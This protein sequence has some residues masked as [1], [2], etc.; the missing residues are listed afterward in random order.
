MMCWKENTH[1][2]NMSLLAQHL[3]IIS[4]LF[5]LFCLVRRWWN[6]LL[7]W[8]VWWPWANSRWIR[9]EV[10]RKDDR[11]PGKGRLRGRKCEHFGGLEISKLMIRCHLCARVNIW[12]NTIAVRPGNLGRLKRTAS[13]EFPDS[14]FA[15][16]H[17]AF[18]V[19][20]LFFSG[21]DQ[22][23]GWNCQDPWSPCCCNVM[24]LL[25]W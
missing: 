12:R 10:R 9:T 8:K 3:Q 5:L 16:G 11:V 20:A 15:Q 21:D 19:T 4:L 6:R 7:S 24:L 18:S 2:C 17:A 25:I 23:W 1:F 13:T 14:P 22:Q